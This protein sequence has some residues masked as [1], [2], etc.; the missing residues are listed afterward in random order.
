MLSV[1]TA[2]PY[3]SCSLVVNVVGVPAAK[4]V[5][6]AERPSLAAAPG[7][8]TTVKGTGVVAIPSVAVIKAVSALYRT[9]EPPTE[10][11]PWAKVIVV[12]EPKLT[13]AAV[14]SVTVGTYKPMVEA[15]LKVNVSGLL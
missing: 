12:G 2:L 3:V 7:F 6:E 4:V 8:T 10:D 15:P 1:V 5:A 13:G 9:I 14:L 11:K